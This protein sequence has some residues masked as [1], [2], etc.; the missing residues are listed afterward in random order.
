MPVVTAHLGHWYSS[1]L[2]VVP[3]VLVAIVLAVQSRRDRAHDAGGN[4]PGRRDD[5]S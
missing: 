1:L 3:V 2:Y 5:G 4:G